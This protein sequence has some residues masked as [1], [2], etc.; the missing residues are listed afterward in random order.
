[1]DINE[2]KIVADSSADVLELSGVGFGLAPLKIITSEKEYVDNGL[3]DVQEMVSDLASYKGK[4]SSSC[5]N[6]SDWLDAFGDAKYVFCVTITSGLSGSYASAVMAKTEYEQKHPDY[7]VFVLDSLSAGPELTLLVYKLRQFIIQGYEFDRVCEEIRNYSQG[8]GLLFVLESLKNFAN[9]GRVKPIVAKAVGLLGIRM[10]GKASDSGDLQPL[11]KCRGEQ[12]ALKE[13]LS[14]LKEEGLLRG[15]V[16]I[17]HC[18]NLNA[19]EELRGIILSEL[20]NATVE[21]GETM[22]LC[23]FYAEK[24]GLLIGFEKM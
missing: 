8:T 6:A 5:P 16:I 14:H 1:M 22:G 19:A 10:V 2:I 17:H 12:K 15:K 7:K 4:S 18:Q 13:V 24:G 9:N 21:I 23:S 3:L 20:P 11:D